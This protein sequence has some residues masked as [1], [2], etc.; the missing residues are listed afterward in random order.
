M[1]QDYSFHNSSNLPPIHPTQQ[2]QQQYT[3]SFQNHSLQQP[4][5]GEERAL[6]S[7]IQEARGNIKQYEM[8]IEAERQREKEASLAL[9]RLNPRPTTSSSFS[10]DSSSFRP[11]YSSL[12]D[13]TSL[14]L[15][16]DS[17]ANQSSSASSSS[18]KGFNDIQPQHIP[19]SSV[20]HHHQP[21]QHDLFAF[22]SHHQRGGPVALPALTPSPITGIED[23]P[24]SSRGN[25]TRGQNMDILPEDPSNSAS[26][27]NIVSNSNPAA[28]ANASASAP[29]APDFSPWRTTTSGTMAPSSVY[30]SAP[31]SIMPS[32]P[33]MHHQF[34]SDL[35]P[36]GYDANYA[37]STTESEPSPPQQMYHHSP[38]THDPHQVQRL[39]QS[40]L[41]TSPIPSTSPTSTRPVTAPGSSSGTSGPQKKVKKLLH[42]REASCHRCSKP[43]CKLLLRGTSEELSVEY[44]LYYECTDC[45]P[46][47]V[48]PTRQ[49][50]KRTRQTEDT[51]MPTVCDVCIRTIGRGGLVPRNRGLP[52]SFAI[53]VVCPSCALKYSRCSD[54]GGG[55]GRV[56]V[57]KWRAKELFENG[58]KTCRL[59]HVRVGG[60]EIELSVWELP[61]EIETRKELPLLISA[62]KTHWSERVLARL[63]IPEVLE[64]AD[65]FGLDGKAKKPERRTYSDVEDVIAKGWPA[66]EKVIKSAP[67]GPHQRRYLG[68]SWAKSRARRERANAKGNA[69]AAK[70]AVDDSDV[71]L[72][73]VRRTN[74]LVPPA[75]T[76]VGMWLVDWDIRNRTT[77]LST[78]VP[79]EPLDAEDKSIIGVGEIL[80]R[81]MHDVE[82]HN[83]KHPEDRWAAPEHIWIAARSIDSLGFAKLNDTL[84]RRRGFMLLDDYL[85][86]HPNLT[87]SIFSYIPEGHTWMEEPE[88]WSVS[89]TSSLDAKDGMIGGNSDILVMVRWLGHDLDMEKLEEI[90]ETEYGRK[91]REMAIAN[92]TRKAAMKQ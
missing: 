67:I 19:R 20:H 3:P 38:L 92:K 89:G 44:N 40:S 27:G 51:T 81:I 39:R 25:S 18:L 63:A 78:S 35:P 23:T 5:Y 17:R 31:P 55:S 22:P 36:L 85:T 69:D 71:V 26:S 8:L 43:I 58:R 6:E 72:E 66:R 62:I 83:E 21:P 10:I 4:S 90:K 73:N 42:E 60:G 16:M 24:S 13:P 46:P 15:L 61:H 53:E 87:R 41:S 49:T 91:S 11:S 37:Y 86:Q 84:S 54:C 28:G 29:F 50:K 14:G 32:P 33:G 56:G 75:S 79:F 52:I 34:A 80:T 2:Q 47:P 12:Y 48:V 7:I 76:I 59:P 82:T 65:E 30:G 9:S 1:D 64:G 77:L 45:L 68:L 88:G 57:G 74:L 70:P